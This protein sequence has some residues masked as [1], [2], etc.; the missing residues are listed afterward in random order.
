M[1]FQELIEILLSKNVYSE[2]KSKEKDLF[3]LIPEL[4]VCKGFNQNNLWHIYDVYEHTLSVVSFVENNI[5]LRLAALFHDI[6]KPETYVEDENGVGHFNN[7]W[8]KS[9]DIFKKYS[10]YFN[11][12]TKDILLI[13]NLIYWHDINVQKLTETELDCMVSMIGSENI[14]L[15]FKLKRADLLSQN[16]IY[17]HLLDSINDTEQFVLKRNKNK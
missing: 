16:P 15:L 13:E 17:H 4:K 5:Y 8:N 9:L 14:P 10:N 7:H 12:S 6:G 3:E 1:G 2:L 11:L